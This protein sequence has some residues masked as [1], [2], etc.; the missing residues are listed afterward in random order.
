MYTWVNSS[1]QTHKFK[2]R[3]QLSPRHRNSFSLAPTSLDAGSIKGPRYQTGSYSP[4]LSVMYLSGSK[5]KD[6][7]TCCRPLLVGW[8][9]S[10]DCIIAIEVE[11]VQKPFCF[12]H[13][14]A[15]L[16]TPTSKPLFESY[17]Y[18]MS[19]HTNRPVL[20]HTLVHWKPACL[21]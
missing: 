17:Y 4:P 20:A 14:Y 18:G 15:D 13:I 5:Q 8:Q 19:V 6:T 3:R 9:V 10:I 12:S 1:G 16:S 2:G 11:F 21:L 7:L